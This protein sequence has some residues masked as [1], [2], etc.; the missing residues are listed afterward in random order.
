[1]TEI[2][3][4][5]FR[6]NISKN[7]SEIAI[8]EAL[9]SIG[10]GEIPLSILNNGEIHELEMERI[11][12]RNWIFIGFEDEVPSPGDYHLRYIGKDEFIFVRD[13]KGSI[14]V[15]LNSCRHRGTAVCEAQSG[16]SS[17]FRCPYHGWTYANNGSLVAYPR[18]ETA[19][20]GMNVK[21]WG[22]I[23]AR[24]ESYDG[25]VFA[26]LDPTAPSLDK[27]LGDMKWY[28]DVNFKA[29]GGMEVVGYPQRWVIDADWKSGAENFTGDN[30]HPLVAHRSLIEAGLSGSWDAF[31]KNKVTDYLVITENQMACIWRLVPPDTN[32]YCGYPEEVYSKFNPNEVNADQFEILRRLNLVALTIFPNM[33]FVHMGPSSDSPEKPESGFLNVRLWKPMGPG[34]M[35]LWSWS[36]VPKR[37][38]AAYKRRIQEIS[39]SQ[40]GPSGN[41]E[42]DD[43]AIWQRISRVSKGTLAKT[44]LLK[45]NFKAGLDGAARN[46]K[47]YGG[48]KGPG[49]CIDN[50]RDTEAGQRTF[51]SRWANE[52]SKPPIIQ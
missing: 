15:I 21:D 36:L 41:A 44:Q 6:N 40:F 3:Q 31:V 45:I 18:K 49:I 37:A 47:I 39:I 7:F 42:V 28:L 2:T 23:R 17:H 13:E 35:E 51:W 27:Y 5:Q 26:C 1:M 25:L 8:D 43:V 19:Y 46:S 34:K 24:V 22:L 10:H 11:F 12:T 50:A 30:F 29:T 32:S 48:W 4:E 20:S 16:N 9:Q 33:S 38:P 14:N 52:I